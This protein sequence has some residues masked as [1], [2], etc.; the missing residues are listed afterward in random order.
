MALFVVQVRYKDDPAIILSQQVGFIRENADIVALD[1]ESLLKLPVDPLGEYYLAII[2]RGH[3][4]V[5][6]STVKSL[7][8]TAFLHDFRDPSGLYQDPNMNQVPLSDLGN[9]VFGLISGDSDLNGVINSADFNDVTSQYLQIG[10]Y[11]ADVDFNGVIN[12]ADFN[13]IIAN[14]FKMSQIPD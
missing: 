2:A 1:G 12:S 13:I 10:Y 3:L 9:G 8:G 6:T 11:L 4:G 14:Y 7:Q 5:M